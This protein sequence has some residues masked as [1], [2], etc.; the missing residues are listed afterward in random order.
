[1]AVAGAAR[2]DERPAISGVS[3]YVRGGVVHCDLRCDNLF[4]E[5]IVGTV[6]SGLPAVVELLYT[7]HNADGKR[8]RRGLHSYELI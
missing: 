5:R 6:E 1:M 2:A 4:T 3:V 8:V 7:M